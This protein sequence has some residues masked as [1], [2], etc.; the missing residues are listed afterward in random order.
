MAFK[1]TRVDKDPNLVAC[2]A[3]RRIDVSLTDS[4]RDLLVVPIKDEHGHVAGSMEVYLAT[5]VAEGGR[6]QLE[7]DDKYWIDVF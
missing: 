4:A 3:K 2:L 5:D 6:A 7:D 1:L